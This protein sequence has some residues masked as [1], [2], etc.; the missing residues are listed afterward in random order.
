M[1]SEWGQGG[2]LVY[3]SCTP[4]STQDRTGRGPGASHGAIKTNRRNGDRRPTALPIRRVRERVRT[5]ACTHHGSNVFLYIIL[6][7]YY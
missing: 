5:N 1:E 3:D 4:V 2:R 6:T 7:N